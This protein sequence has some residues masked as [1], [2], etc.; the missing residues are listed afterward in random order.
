LVDVIASLE[1][2]RN[3]GE[4]VLY[5]NGMTHPA[6]ARDQMAMRGFSNVYLLTD[7][8]QG[9]LDHCLRPAS[10]RNEPLPEED[11]QQVTTWR[12]YFLADTTCPPGSLKQLSSDKLQPVT[13][14]SISKLNTLGGIYLASQPFPDDLR[15]A[16]QGGVKTVVSLRFPDEIDWDEAS[17]A[18]QSGMAFIDVPFKAPETLTDAVFD[19]TRTLLKDSS[20]RPLLLHCHSANRVGAIWLAHRVLDDGLSLADAEKEATAVGLKSPDY[21]AK[22]QDY[23]S[24]MQKAKP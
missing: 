10:L 6:Q 13:C 15:L 7:G 22:A 23:V 12:N 14:G 19:K 24:R 16:Q 4:I 17:V 9:F 18:K 5:S 21:L 11:A 2:Y 20:Q 8:L 1:P 3:T